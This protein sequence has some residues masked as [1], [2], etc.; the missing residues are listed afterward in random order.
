MMSRKLVLSLGLPWAAS[1]TI[2]SLDSMMDIPPKNQINITLDYE[3]DCPF[4]YEYIEGPLA[5]PFFINA[6][7]SRKIG[8][9][10]LPYG[11]AQAWDKCQH[12]EKECKH[13]LLEA[14]VLHYIPDTLIHLPL[15]QCMEKKFFEDKKDKKKSPLDALKACTDN[16]ISEITSCYGDGKGKEGR[17]LIEKI[18]AQTDKS[19]RYVPWVIINGVHDLAAQNALP[20]AICK[21]DPSIPDCHKHLRQEIVNQITEEEKAKSLFGGLSSKNWYTVLYA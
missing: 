15:I 18:A 4:C 20:Q 3:A 8:L 12:G 17:A 13:N 1:G 6:L 7:K 9:T 5:T 11:N 16:Y 21:I 14:C 2:F 19:H 10:M